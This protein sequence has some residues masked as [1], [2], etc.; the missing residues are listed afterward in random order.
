MGEEKPY[1]IR[2]AEGILEPSLEP[3]WSRKSYKDPGEAVMTWWNGKK[4]FGCAHSVFENYRTHPCG[5]TAKYDPDQNGNP[6]KCGHHSQAALDRKEAKRKAREDAWRAEW[7]HKDAV[8]KHNAERD[9]IIRKIAGG[10]NDP[11]GLC[12][13]WLDRKPEQP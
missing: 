7:A 9:D 8:R 11:R 13:D 4:K 2:N 10:H 1:L 5:K 6:T 12:Q 3:T